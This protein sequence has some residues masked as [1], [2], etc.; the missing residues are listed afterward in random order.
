LIKIFLEYLN[1]QHVPGI[2]LSTTSENTAACRLYEKM[3]FELLF[4]YPLRHFEGLVNHPIHK[5]SYG[6]KIADQATN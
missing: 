6:L 3:G 2:H 5:R 1:V 4:E